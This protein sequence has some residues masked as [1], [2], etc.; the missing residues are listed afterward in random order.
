MKNAT[1]V[2]SLRREQGSSSG[3]GSLSFEDVAV[4][5]TREEWQSLD[6]S[7]KVLYKEVMLENYSNLVSVGYQGTKP[8]SLFKLE[9]GEPP[10]IVEGAAHSQTCPDLHYLGKTAASEP[11]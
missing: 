3:E 6:W 10:W 7:Q 8:D 11:Q 9:Q 4:D 1:I 5:F 2:M